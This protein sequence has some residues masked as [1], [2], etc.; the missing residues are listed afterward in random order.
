LQIEVFTIR[1]LVFFTKPQYT[2]SHLQKKLIDIWKDRYKIAIGQWQINISFAIRLVGL[3]VHSFCYRK[4]GF[5]KRFL[6]T[7]D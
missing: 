5:Q 2:A 7:I 4:K 6:L 3:A 1:P